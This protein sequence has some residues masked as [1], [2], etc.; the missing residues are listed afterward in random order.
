MVGILTEVIPIRQSSGK[1]SE[2][3]FRVDKRDSTK[4]GH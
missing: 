3:D 4:R 1:A 2:L